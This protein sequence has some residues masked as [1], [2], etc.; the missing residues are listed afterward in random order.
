M[1]TF[2]KN[3]TLD[4]YRCAM[5]IKENEL[6]NKH[7]KG[8]FHN[9]GIL[10]FYSCQL[11]R[12]IFTMFLYLLSYHLIQLNFQIDYLIVLALLAHALTK[13]PIIILFLADPHQI[14][15]VFLFF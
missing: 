12:I 4:E 5:E 9:L 10:K 13:H 15:N 2:L 3:F 8:L 11:N 1:S 6:I 14:V 7:H